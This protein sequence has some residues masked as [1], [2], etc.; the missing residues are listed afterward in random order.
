MDQWDN[1]IPPLN[2]WNYSLFKEWL[3][4]FK[5]NLIDGPEIVSIDEQVFK[6]ST[7]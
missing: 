3:E 7:R 2:L 1:Y 5:E 4:E 6:G